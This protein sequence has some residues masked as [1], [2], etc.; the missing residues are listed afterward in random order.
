MGTIQL[1]ILGCG[2]VILSNRLD[3]KQTHSNA[4]ARL[5]AKL[6]FISDGLQIFVVTQLH[7]VAFHCWRTVDRE[8]TSFAATDERCSSLGSSSLCHLIRRRLSS[9]LLSRLLLTYVA[10]FESHFPFNFISS[11]SIPIVIVAYHVS[12]SCTTH[13]FSSESRTTIIQMGLCRFPFNESLSLYSPFHRFK[14]AR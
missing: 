10:P 13:S 7:V 11:R 4:F 8:M 2:L 3:P 5:F 1:I 12:P 9:L 6:P 14:E